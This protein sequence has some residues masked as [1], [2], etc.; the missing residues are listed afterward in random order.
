[1]R[2]PHRHPGIPPAR[3]VVEDSSHPHGAPMT[4]SPALQ[5][6]RTSLYLARRPS[7]CP[8]ARH[9]AAAALQQWDATGQEKDDVLLV[10]SELVTN[11]LIHAAGPIRAHLARDT[12][13]RIHVQVDD[14]GP[15]HHGADDGDGQDDQ[16]GRG[17]G[18]VDHL[19]HHHG[20]G[21]APGPT[22]ALR[23][24]LPGVS[25][26]CRNAVPSPAGTRPKLVRASTARPAARR[27]NGRPT[28]IKGHC[29]GRLS[30]GFHLTEHSGPGLRGRKLPLSPGRRCIARDQDPPRGPPSAGWTPDRPRWTTL[31]R[32]H[33]P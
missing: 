20:H 10:M 19:A 4:T 23:Y 18:I 26:G 31:A 21:P 13:G 12:A 29:F 5:R 3:G 15:T 2:G 33:S 30:C 32:S 6:S 1:M 9:W 22:S 24:P 8:R 7:A 14:G 28:A 11:A 17:L 16:H 27:H 25:T